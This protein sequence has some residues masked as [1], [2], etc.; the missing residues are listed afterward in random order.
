MRYAGMLKKAELPVLDVG[1][2]FGRNAVALALLGLDVVCV[3][4]NPTRLTTL[5][6]L[7]PEYIEKMKPKEV[8]GK[9]YAICTTLSAFNWP[10]PPNCFS[11]ILC[12]HFLDIGLFPFFRSS[13]G[14]GGYLYVETFGGHGQNYLDL[15]RAGLLR[16]LL[17]S[18]FRPLHYRERKVGPA[19]CEAVSVKLFAQRA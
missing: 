8:T 3:D 17:S 12:V 15:P 1:S 16:E 4:C 13:L 11:A 5:V 7:A 9:L 2:G 19:D 18:Q 14:A 6:K 10:F